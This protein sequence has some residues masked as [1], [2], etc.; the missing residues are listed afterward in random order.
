MR[1]QAKRK[2]NRDAPEMHFLYQNHEPLAC[3]PS[4][5][6]V[7]YNCQVWSVAMATGDKHH[8]H[9]Q[10]LSAR[11]DTP[12]VP[13]GMYDETVEVNATE[14]ESPPT[15]DEEA[16]KAAMSKFNPPVRHTARHDFDSDSESESEAD[17]FGTL[18]EEDQV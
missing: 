6:K 1:Y 2:K 16:L 5:P 8:K 4:H 15:S 3:N 18:S 13:Q 17:K 7:T 11:Q 10:T 9:C 12:G 14:I